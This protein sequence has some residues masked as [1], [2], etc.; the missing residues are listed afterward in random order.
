[1]CV[2]IETSCSNLHT[3]Q[4]DPLTRKERITVR[5]EGAEM[6][7]VKVSQEIVNENYDA[8]EL[9]TVEEVAQRFNVP[10][11]W[12]VPPQNSDRMEI[13]EVICSSPLICGRDVR[14]PIVP[15]SV[16]EF[17]FPKPRP[18][19]NRN[20]GP[21]SSTKCSPTQCASAEIAV[22]GPVAVDRAREAVDRLAF[23]TDD[24][25]A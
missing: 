5:V 19:G 4:R 24:R 12:A 18:N 21:P 8:D 13:V 22:D 6:S 23:R 20:P 25:E 11:T 15:S 10:R 2:S 16:V 14:T 17:M 9:L 7:D 3:N 1:M